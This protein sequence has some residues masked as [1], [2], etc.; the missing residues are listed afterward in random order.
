[1]EKEC[2]PNYKKN[3]NY[4][5]NKKYI[6]FIPNTPFSETESYFKKIYPFYIQLK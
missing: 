2:F 6:R 5:N 1:M 3:Q 4:K